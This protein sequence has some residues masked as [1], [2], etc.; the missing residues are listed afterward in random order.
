MPLPTISVLGCGWL[1]LPLAERLLADGYTVKGSTTTPEKVPLLANKGIVPYQLKLMP[2]PDGDLTDFLRTD[3]LL[4]D[5]PPRVSVQGDGFHSVQVQA[6]SDAV[7]RS[8]VQ[9]VIYISSTSVYPEYSRVVTEEDVTGPGESADA[10]SSSQLVVAE[11]IILRLAP[12]RQTTVLRCAGLMGYDRIP[13]KYVAGR[14]VDSGL[15]PVNY[16]HR[17]DAVGLITAVLATGLQ[18]TFNIVAP[19]HPT[20]EAIY[21][22]SCAD[23]GYA[24]PSFVD[25]LEALPFKVVSGKKLAGQLDYLFRYPDPL[26][27]RYS[28]PAASV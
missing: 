24:L 8:S 10:N 1:G 4:I 9:W 18:G 12:T 17:D 2:Q 20:R 27:F 25:P 23:F 19:L 13:G 15:L 6:I 7:Q 21:R 16:V 11:Q 28:S 22:K 26:I 5:I 3:I 14:T